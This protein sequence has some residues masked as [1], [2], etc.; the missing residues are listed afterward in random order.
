M[1]ADIAAAVSLRGGRGVVDEGSGGASVTD[2]VAA[3]AGGPP[4][5]LVV[6]P[7]CE[8]VHALETTTSA[9]TTEQNRMPC[10]N[11]VL[12][13]PLSRYRSASEAAS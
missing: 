1:C 9:S 2:G 3:V 6:E 5:V 4:V 12:T 11:R 7:D 13:P 10:A 8:P